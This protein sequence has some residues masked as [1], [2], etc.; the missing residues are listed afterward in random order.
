MLYVLVLSVNLHAFF[1]NMLKYP[2]FRGR[3]GLSNEPKLSNIGPQIT[4]IQAF[5]KL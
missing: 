3:I 5:P 4:E 1:H 2:M